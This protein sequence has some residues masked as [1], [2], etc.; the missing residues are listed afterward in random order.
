MTFSKK[1]LLVNRHI[2]ISLSLN[3]ILILSS[4]E[5]DCDQSKQKVWSEQKIRNWS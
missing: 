1:K 5:M 4:G 2:I 3:L